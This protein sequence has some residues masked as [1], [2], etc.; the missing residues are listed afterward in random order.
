MS[1]KL[2]ATSHNKVKTRAWA[3]ILFFW[4]CQ[5]GTT[6]A[7]TSAPSQ[8]FVYRQNTRH[9]ATRWISNSLQHHPSFERNPTSLEPIVAT[10][11]TIPP[12]TT[13]LQRWPNV[14]HERERD[15][16]QRGRVGQARV[17]AESLV[18]NILKQLTSLTRT[19]VGKENTRT[20]EQRRTGRN[21]DSTQQA[22]NHNKVLLTPWPKEGGT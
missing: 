20:T 7:K 22:T 12:V 4:A 10:D 5:S 2:S 14:V 16:P 15:L 9:G 21:Q 13:S 3:R 18:H 19:Q 11:L 1:Q 8:L 17:C 6:L